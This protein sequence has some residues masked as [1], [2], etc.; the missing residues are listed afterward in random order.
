MYA[1]NFGRFQSLETLLGAAELLADRHD[2]GFVLV[3][4]GVEEERL[5][6]IVVQRGLTNVTFAGPQPYERMASVLAL[7]DVQFVGLQDI[8][9]FE[10]TLPSK[11]QAALAAGRPIL[12]ALTGDGAQAVI[13][14]RA[15]MVV[16]PGCPHSLAS[17]IR[18]LEGLSKS[19]L[20][21]Y[22]RAGRSFYEST[23]SELVVASSLSELLDRAAKGRA[24]A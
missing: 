11:L 22:G 7:G 18:S 21:A 10:M 12:A 3:G 9:L 2:I 15:G 6:R 23:Y 19:T 4:S 13:D 14:A 20:A 24:V 5:R 1:G 8:P 16:E 17:A